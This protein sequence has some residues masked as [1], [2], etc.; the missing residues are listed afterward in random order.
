MTETSK[1]FISFA[2]ADDA[3]RRSL[4]RVLEGRQPALTPVVVTAR[5]AP[6]K[7]LAEKVV[8]GIKEASHFV[9]ILTR[10]SIQNQWV[11]QEIGYAVAVGKNPLALLDQSIMTDLKGFI[12]AQQD[13]PFH[14]S[15]DGKPRQ[16][17]AAFRRACLQLRAH[18]VGTSTIRLFQSRITPQLLR[19]GARYTTVAE[20]KGDVRH[21][22]FDNRVVHL[23][24][25]FRR[26]NP[27]PETFKRRPGM[28]SGVTPGILNG[29]VDVRREYSH[30]TAG[31]PT[32]RYKIYVRL[33]SHLEPG[34]KGRQ[35]VAQNEHD[36][37]IE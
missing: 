2:Q 5:R 9:A 20:F 28:I 16:E 4:C 31:W 19:A 35:L 33:Y 6:G 12:H 18:I 32:G 29:N 21:G 1:V 17:A 13:L 11:N 14:Y 10:T 15:T 24:S 25:D 27:D 26:W 22:F 8:E 34:Q 37:V 23:D 30:D 3:K 36:V 7:P